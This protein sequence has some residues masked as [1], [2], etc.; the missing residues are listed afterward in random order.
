MKGDEAGAQIAPLLGLSSI[1]SDRARALDLAAGG[2]LFDF[3]HLVVQRRLLGR[4]RVFSLIRRAALVAH[5]GSVLEGYNGIS[6][7]VRRTLVRVDIIAF[8]GVFCA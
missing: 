2:R 3:F 7:V 4:R 8:R 6:G 1:W 5:V